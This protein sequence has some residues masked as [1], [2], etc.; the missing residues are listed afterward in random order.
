M[1]LPELTSIRLGYNAFVFDAKKE[2]TFFTMRSDCG[3]ARECVV[4]P[5]LK[6]FSCEDECSQSLTNAHTI[7]IESGGRCSE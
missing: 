6:V 1:D 7:T 3:C 2:N 5:A 4:L